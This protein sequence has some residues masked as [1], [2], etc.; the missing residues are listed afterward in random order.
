[1]K[2]IA[3]TC[4]TSLLVLA[5]PASAQTTTFVNPNANG[6]YTINRP[7]GPTTFVTPNAGGG[8]TANT[9]G[10]GTSFAS[11]NAGGGYTVHSYPAPRP[12]G[13]YGR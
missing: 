4:A 1:M 12:G 7:G 8:Y 13:L 10:V 2:A 5:L 11:P 9:P 6:G 3:I